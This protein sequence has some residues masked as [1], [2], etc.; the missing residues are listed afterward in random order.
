MGSRNRCRGGVGFF[1]AS[2]DRRAGEICAVAIDY[3]AEQWR[4]PF[5]GRCDGLPREVCKASGIAPGIADNSS[6]FVVV[7]GVDF[8]SVR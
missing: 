3:L 1:W 7:G 5:G 6:S 8:S 2:G 4:L